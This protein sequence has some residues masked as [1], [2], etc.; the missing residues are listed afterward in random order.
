M[1][2]NVPKSRKP[3]V[4]IRGAREQDRD[5]ER[6]AVEEL[7]RLKKRHRQ[8]LDSLY[9]GYALHEILTD[10]DGKPVDYRFLE[11][12]HQLE[13]NT[14]LKA[15][16]IVGRTA[17]EI[18]PKTEQIWI[19]T[20]G[21]VAREGKPVW[22]MSYAAE[23]GRFYEVRA[24]PVGGSLV[25]TLALDVT[26]YRK[27]AM[28]L[29]SVNRALRTLS[30]CNQVL[31]RADD[32][33]VLLQ[34]ICHVIA[35]EGGY[36]MAWVGYV[37]EARKTLRAMA[38][39]GH[40]DGFVERVVQKGWGRDYEGGPACR[41][42]RTGRP[43]IV[44]S[45]MRDQRTVAWRD[46][47]LKRGYQSVGAYPLKH[48]G[49]RI[50]AIA[51]YSDREE[52]F[53]K[54]ESKLLQ[55]LADDLSFGISAIRSR[56]AREQAELSLAESRRTLATL[57]DNI[58]GMVYRCRNDE[59]W[60]ME[61][62]SAGV[63]QI[64]GYRP[65]Q[66]VWNAEV[67]YAEIIHP[68]DRERIWDEVQ[69]YLA[70][71]EQFV[72]EYRIVTASGEIKWV[73][74]RGRGVFDN[75]GK[76]EALEGVV[77]DATWRHEAMEALEQEAERGRR[78]LELYENAPRLSDKELYDFALDQAVYLTRSS[79]GFMHRVSE[80]QK[81]IELVTWNAEALK[82]CDAVVNTHYPIKSAGNWADCVRYSKPVVYND[83][84][85]SPNQKGLPEGH[86]PLR[87][88]MS[89]PVV[90][91]GKARII[92]GVGNKESHYTEADVVQLQL[93]ANELHKVILQRR[94]EEEV[95]ESRERFNRLVS[96][97][98]DVV[99]TAS[100]DGSVIHDVNQTFEEIYGIPP[101]A[102]REDPTLWLTNVHPDDRHIAEASSK[103]LLEKGSTVAEY[104]IVKPDGSIIWLH[105]RKSVI[106]DACG[107]P[108]QIGGVA[109]DITELVKYR[110]QLEGMVEE[111]TVALTRALADTSEA[112]DR[113][114]TIIKA[115]GDGLVV[116]D[117]YNRVVLM[118]PAAED[119][120][121][122]MFS[123][124]VGSEIDFAV[125]DET[126]RDKIKHTLSKREEDYEFDF[127][128]NGT[129]GKARVMAA[130]TNLVKDLSGEVTGIVTTFHD[131][132]RDRE[133]DRMKTEFLSTAAHEL[134]TPLTSIQGFSEILLTRL[135]LDE[136]QKRKYLQ[137]I[138]TGAV[139]LA[140]I[141]NDLLDISRIE[142][143]KG[144][145]F[146]LRPQSISRLCQRAVSI[147][148]EAYP[149]RTFELRLPEEPLMVNMDFAKLHQ[150]LENILS[151]AV[152][153]A[154]ES[155]SIRVAL[156]KEEGLAVLS[157]QDWGKGM[158][159]EQVIRVF[160][161]FWRADASNTAIPGTG[162]GMAIVKHIVE[163]HHGEVK[164][165]S[166][167]GK[168][169]TVTFLLPVADDKAAGGSNHVN[170]STL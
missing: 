92:F 51:M 135:N 159:T 73:V 63:L 67:S 123:E 157:V 111:R 160:D 15:K 85:H 119:L 7:R 161:K 21:Q 151:N 115:V 163:A 88:F 47:A 153:Y 91:G 77:T 23:F 134:R 4:A 127:V 32:E 122:T 72:L 42:M 124:V 102:F 170:R 64:T 57:M 98:N 61:F 158:T 13:M 131:V 58:P 152:K 94:F 117:K 78:M 154:P 129:D 139:T 93:V 97:L 150:A 17:R 104:R 66:I 46:E 62:V 148:R 165:D 16:D 143:G 105:D 121:G 144:F 33:N 108:I 149:D 113:I 133:L 147:F 100:L 83:Y 38:V 34:R 5:R 114:S 6:T 12:N 28:D 11:V 136:E 109:S 52:M 145:S 76:L 37:D 87:R 137:Y 168:G 71:R 79:I 2:R 56:R 84:Q 80:D 125:K 86:T 166:T 120:L 95:R 43:L 128:A 26:D 146:D 14:R 138:N 141:I 25:A 53:G 126:L 167:P 106:R 169:T 10:Q 70:T 103:E 30:G 90:E 99:W 54:V 107:N 50:G 45:I 74:E 9:A 65:D 44:N 112:H 29:E 27:A 142:S 60:T 19:D 96:E 40:N 162:L 20:F 101:E 35:Q 116:T 59:K 8:L 155:R 41:T 55:E 140:I 156:R 130:R 118:N 39:S 81:S 89:I 48:D 18:F 75:A 164:V 69:A 24:Y 22:L 68:D 3:G 1:E 110:E 82:N 31:I 36:R 132:T 49:A